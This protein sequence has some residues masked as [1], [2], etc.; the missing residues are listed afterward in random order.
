MNIRPVGAELFNEDRRTDGQTDS[1]TKLIVAFSQIW[2]RAQ[3]C[4]TSA[5]ETY[6][7]QKPVQLHE[8]AHFPRTILL[9]QSAYF[10]DVVCE[11]TAQQFQANIQNSRGKME[12][13]T[14]Y[15]RPDTDL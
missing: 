5:V 14:S 15:S 10:R 7:I 2:D 3:E 11:M 8:T 4:V 13:T 12:P 9:Q 6:A 1:M